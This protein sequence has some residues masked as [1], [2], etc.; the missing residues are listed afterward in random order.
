MFQ[1][2]RVSSGIKRVP[3]DR[4]EGGWTLQGSDELV[5]SEELADEMKYEKLCASGDC[6]SMPAKQKMQLRVNNK[7]MFCS[8]Y[9]I[10]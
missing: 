1:D 10:F 3:G 7:Y 8:F 9:Y 4:Q 6:S 5:N 2:S